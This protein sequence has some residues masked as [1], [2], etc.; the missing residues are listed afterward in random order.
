MRMH[1]LCVSAFSAYQRCAPWLRWSSPHWRQKQIAGGG[2]QEPGVSVCP[3]RAHAGTRRVQ[4]CMVAWL[5][6][7][8]LLVGSLYR[9]DAP[10]CGQR[11]IDICAC[12]AVIWKICPAGVLRVRES[13]ECDLR[14]P[15]MIPTLGMAFD[16]HHHHIRRCCC[17]IG[18]CRSCA[19]RSLVDRDCVCVCV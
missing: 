7:G 16:C 13:A 4:S 17:L 6:E 19:H 2:M 3:A 8:P 14:G 12:L 5:I 11:M 15:R 1:H 18:Q 10:I 9:V